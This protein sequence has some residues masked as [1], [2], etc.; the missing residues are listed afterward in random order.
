METAHFGFLKCFSYNIR[1][2]GPLLKKGSPKLP[3]F[4][5]FETE[6]SLQRE[7][8]NTNKKQN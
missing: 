5:D 8:L 6:K 2:A 1:S 3:T 7:A 4:L